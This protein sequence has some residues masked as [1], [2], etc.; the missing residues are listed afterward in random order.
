AAVQNVF[1]LLA[2]VSFCLAIGELGAWFLNASRPQ[3][4]DTLE[5]NLDDPDL[6]YS[7]EPNQRAQARELHGQRVLFD[8][9]YTID[10]N[11]FRVVPTSATLAQCRVAFLGD[12]F[13]FGWGLADAETMPNQ[14][15]A[16]SAGLYRGYNLAQSGYGPHQMLRM[17]ETERFDRAVGD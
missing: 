5:F 9:T 2:S 12:S 14:F 8:V 4:T 17:L 11:G 15:V 3:M 16:A 13:T 6:G 10:G 1:V 7:L